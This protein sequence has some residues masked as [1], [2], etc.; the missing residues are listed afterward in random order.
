MSDTSN[1]IAVLAC[2]VCG[3]ELDTHETPHI[4]W[5]RGFTRLHIKPTEEA[6]QHL[7]DCLISEASDDELDADKATSTGDAGKEAAGEQPDT[8]GDEPDTASVVETPEKPAPATKARG[9]KG[10]SSK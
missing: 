1:F 9:S 6:G 5:K 3:A 10:T 8:K 2:P 4:D 7:L